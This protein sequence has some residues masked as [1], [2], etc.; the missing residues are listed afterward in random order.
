MVNIDTV[1]QK[2]LTLANKE[3]RGYITP[4]E[5]NLLADKAQLDIFNNYFHD[6]KTSYYKSKNYS[7]GV[8]ETEM[9]HEKMSYL[10][11]T[12]TGVVSRSTDGNAVV[13]LPDSIYKIA[14]IYLTTN[15]YSQSQNSTTSVVTN[16]PT[17]LDPQVEVSRINRQDLLNINGNPLTKP[18]IKRPVY[19]QDANWDSSG[20]HQSWLELHP[21]AKY[22][23]TMVT[24]LLDNQAILPSTDLTATPE[25]AELGSTGV[26]VLTDSSDNGIQQQVYFIADVNGLVDTNGLFLGQSPGATITFDY[27]RKPTKPYWG[28]VVVNEKALYNTNTSVNFDLH[29]MEEEVLVS[30]ILELTGI[31]IEKPQL[32]QAAMVD[33]QQTKQ[34]QND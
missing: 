20:N 6:L 18:S 12:D 15:G 13:M 24:G 16:I 33:K 4:Q 34:E 31:T 23:R 2:V 19:I 32:Q 9:M 10:R 29:P 25:G 30:R 5:F 21:A 1:Y 17:D 27:W 14:T 3:Q 8:D 26:F 22:T 7:E 11:Q 28:Y